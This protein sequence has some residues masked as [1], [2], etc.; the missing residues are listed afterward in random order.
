MG[1]VD[2]VKICH[3]VGGDDVDID[4]N[5]IFANI[6]TAQT[7]QIPGAAKHVYL[8]KT[9]IFHNIISTFLESDKCDIPQNKENVKKK[10]GKGSKAKHRKKGKAKGAKTKKQRIASD[11]QPVSPPIA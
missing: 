10:V 5:K 3:I 7:V 1:N 11:Q 8:D 6:D 9:K 4:D 2:E